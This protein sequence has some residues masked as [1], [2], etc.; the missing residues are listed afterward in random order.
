MTSNAGLDPLTA[1]ELSQAAYTPWAT[2]SQGAQ[3]N[4]FS[5][6]ELSSTLP[7]GLSSTLQQAGW[8][9][10]TA[11]SGTDP[12]SNNQFITFVNV[13]AQEVVIA[14]KG[15]D[16]ISNFASDLVDFGGSEWESLRPAFGAKF[17]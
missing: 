9:V 11:H 5:S 3:L 6:I 15:S 8:V 16:N 14:F 10:D 1:S 7:I 12:S 2:Y 4:G 17:N 13:A